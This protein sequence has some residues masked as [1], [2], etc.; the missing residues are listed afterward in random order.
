[1]KSRLLPRVATVGLMVLL[2]MSAVIHPPVETSAGATSPAQASSSGLF[3]ITLNG[4]TVENESDDD[5]IEGD[6][7]RD[8]IF[9]T[10][11][12]WELDEPGR[13]IGSPRRVTSR[14]MGDIGG[15]GAQVMAG[16]GGD[17]GGLRTGDQVPS[18]PTRDPWRRTEATRT[19]GRIPMIL[20]QVRLVYKQNVVVV[21]PLIWEWDSPA[22][23]KSQ[24]RW[25]RVRNEL[26]TG[27]SSGGHALSS[28]RGG[29]GRASDW[30]GLINW[31]T[32]RVPVF[33]LVQVRM[34]A[35]KA[36]TRPIGW[37]GEGGAF[38]LPADS[39]TPQAIALSFEGAV[40][41]A[42][43]DYAGL[44]PGIVRVRYT[45]QNDHGD[46]TLFIQIERLQ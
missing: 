11:D 26:F 43:S 21:S 30:G 19:D 31:P 36:G 17:G 45:D 13:I 25:G 27:T 46:Y 23:S 37:G 6:G 5:I 44:G 29:A 3:R 42:K 16:S 7:K 9:I 20:A 2:L 33:P 18:R 4:F 1:M 34:G 22:T 40:E 15:P 35:N 32:G 12:T 8:E 24:E 14:V 28:P 10:A 41:A 38:T 39:I